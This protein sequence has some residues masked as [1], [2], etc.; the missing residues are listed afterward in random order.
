MKSHK[1]FLG[2]MSIFLIETFQILSKINHDETWII[3]G[4]EG[5]TNLQLWCIQLSTHFHH[6]SMGS[7]SFHYKWVCDL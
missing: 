4:D 5:M 2:V 7:F 6:P 1:Y 3:N